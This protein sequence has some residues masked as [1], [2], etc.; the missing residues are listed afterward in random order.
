M[1]WLVACA[2]AP[3][4]VPGPAGAAET[5]VPGPAPAAA[6]TAERAELARV[7]FGRGQELAGA[8][9]HS[10][11]LPHFVLAAQSYPDWALAHLEEARCRMILAQ[12]EAEIRPALDR[13]LALAPGNPRVHFAFGRFH[14]NFG[15][16]DDACTAYRR[17]LALRS[18]FPEAL[19][20]LA[21]LEEE[22][23]AQREARALFERAFALDRRNVGAALGAAR[24]AEAGGDVDAAEL[25]LK[26]VIARDPDNM[27]HRQKLVDLY[28]RSGQLKK[29]KKLQAWIERQEGARQRRMRPLKPSRR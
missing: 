16:R 11:A 19:Y 24:L 8:G 20:Q 28:R 9:R 12:P 7:E 2:G 25:M 13:A 29:A 10:E 26:R 6:L 21:L 23:G 17:A 3:P 15:R 5:A 1:T 27:G 14:E 4:P 18:S 22:A